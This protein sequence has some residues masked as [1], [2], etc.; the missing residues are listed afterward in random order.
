MKTL[1]L[2]S[3]LLMQFQTCNPEKP[4][5]INDKKYLLIT[6][7][8]AMDSVSTLNRENYFVVN[9]ESETVLIKE[10]KFLKSFSDTSKHFIKNS[11]VVL[12]PVF[13]I[14]S[15][16]YRIVIRNVK[17]KAGNVITPNPTR[18]IVKRK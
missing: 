15:K 14:Y 10:V 1:L 9:D 2:I 8:E 11:I 13:P 18:I 4:I 17:D 6:F 5:S 12:I 7:T 3:F 16:S